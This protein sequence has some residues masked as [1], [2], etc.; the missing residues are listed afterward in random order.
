MEKLLSIA[1]A[2]SDPNRVR[3]V[4]ALENG[5]LCVCQI[6]ALLQ[7]APSTVSKHMSILRGAGLVEWRK[8]ERWMY[9]RLPERPAPHIQGALDWIRRSL[10][11]DPIVHADSTRLGKILS[12]PAEEICRLVTAS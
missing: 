3:A 12:R 4:R 9:Y 5:E 2:L 11:D 1:K 10:A 7:L 8:E 6:T